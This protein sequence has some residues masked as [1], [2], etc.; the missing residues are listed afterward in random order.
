MFK[1]RYTILD[2]SSGHAT[3]LKNYDKLTLDII[4][5]HTSVPITH[6]LDTK[7]GIRFMDE[8][9]LLDLTKQAKYKQR[10]YEYKPVLH[11]GQLKLF[12]SEVEFLTKVLLMCPKDTDI[13]FIYAGAAPGH[14]IK[15]LASLFSKIH[16]E[17]YDPNDFVVNDTDMIKTH[18]QFFTDEDAKQWAESG[19]Y[20]VFCSDVRSEPATQE[21]VI[22]N[23]Q[24][25][26]NWWKIMNPEWSM[27]KFR[28]PWEP[29]T[30]EYPD[31]EIYA[32][33]YPG[34]TS[35]ETRLI[36]KKDAPLKQYNNT[37]YE[38]ACFYHNSITR[39]KKYQTVLGAVALQR[40]GVDM[41]YD[42]T[43]FIHI[44]HKYL[45]VMGKSPAGLRMLIKNVQHEISFGKS[46]VLSQSIKYIGDAVTHLTKLAYVPCKNARCLICIS[47]ESHITHLKPS[48]ATIANE[49]LVIR[50]TLTDFDVL[51][52]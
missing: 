8:L 42:C 46:T 51:D 7:D 11:W 24:M 5:G 32:Q 33:A 44:M 16:F 31:G 27:F 17:L 28:L 23:M 12:L 34:P 47:G 35:T 18:V 52:L 3:N 19:K 1:P 41:C 25:Q 29:G 48:R 22:H 2:A 9:R 49:S 20:I 21:N 26:L 50:K 37:E 30:T 10:Q 15:F 38:D 45:K 4:Q 43:S 13:W 14:H 40:D 36:C 6:T 39:S